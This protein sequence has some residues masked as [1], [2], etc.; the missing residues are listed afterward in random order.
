MQHGDVERVVEHVGS[1]RQN[2]GVGHHHLVSAIAT[3]FNQASAKVASERETTALDDFGNVLTV[4]ASDVRG[5]QTG[6]LFLLSVD[7]CRILQ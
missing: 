2:N 7:Q 4:A 5:E 3:D 1:I 6:R